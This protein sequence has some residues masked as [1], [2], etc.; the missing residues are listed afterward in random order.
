MTLKAV[1]AAAV[2]G[3]LIA[4]E[5]AAARGKLGDLGT[6]T[7][8]LER[9]LFVQTTEAELL[10]HRMQELEARLG[11]Q[12]RL[13]AERDYQLERVKSELQDARKIETDLRGEIA[14]AGSRREIIQADG[15]NAR[16]LHGYRAL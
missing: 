16:V 15:V 9:Q 13:L 11:D 12:G 2:L 10:Q 14:T 1:P 5:L 4:S 7:G 3:T 6:R 8:E